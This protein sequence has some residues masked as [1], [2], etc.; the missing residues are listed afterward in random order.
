MTRWASELG[1]GLGPEGFSR[2]SKGLGPA[3]AI[4]LLT[5]AALPGLLHLCQVCRRRMLPLGSTSSCK[6]LVS[7]AL[8]APSNPCL[9]HQL[10]G[11]SLPEGALSQQAAMSQCHRLYR[12]RGSVRMAARGITRRRKGEKIEHTLGDRSMC[13]DWGL[14][15]TLADTLGGGS[16][17]C[18]E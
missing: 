11:S 18:L 4:R 8:P 3:S 15:W 16:Q 2:T 10:N 5:R 12:G 7:W 14:A 13:L 6:T 1:D 17:G 9:V